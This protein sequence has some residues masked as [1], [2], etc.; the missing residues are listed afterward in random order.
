MSKLRKT[1]TLRRVRKTVRPSEKRKEPLPAWKKELFS[2]TVPLRGKIEVIFSKTF[3]EKATFD[4]SKSVAE[5]QTIEQRRMRQEVGDS[6]GTTENM[7]SELRGKSLGQINY[8]REQGLKKI[9]GLN[10]QY[11]D[12][13]V[14]VSGERPRTAKHRMA[15]ESYKKI[16]KNYFRYA[17]RIYICDFFLANALIESRFPNWTPALK[18][19]VLFELP[20]NIELLYPQ[21][22]ANLAGKILTRERGNVAR[23]Y[24]TLAGRKLPPKLKTIVDNLPLE[25][26][27]G[28][29]KKLS[30][31]G[32]TTLKNADKPRIDKIIRGK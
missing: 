8:I 21:H 22:Y 5:Q 24:R 16:A 3:I 26:I 20:K 29:I 32:D 4:P 9:K 14:A 18:R 17:H 27:P 31:F 30:R 12:A 25:K 7:L 11:K 1:N 28:I 10:K 13:L 15:L 23:R 2:K 19:Q 6:F